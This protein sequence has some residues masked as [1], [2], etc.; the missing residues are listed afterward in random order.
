MPRQARTKG[1]DE[2]GVNYLKHN[3][4]AGR[5]F[6]L[7]RLCRP[8]GPIGPVAPGRRDCAG[9]GV[10][11]PRYRA[12]CRRNSRRPPGSRRVPSAGL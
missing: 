3:A 12:A 1:K 8:S 7:V 6:L 9:H 10:G 5:R 11:R 2:L 4:I